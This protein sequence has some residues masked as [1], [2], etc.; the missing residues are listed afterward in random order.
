MFRRDFGYAHVR[1]ALKEVDVAVEAS[2]GFER[3][4]LIAK[5]KVAHACDDGDDAFSSITPEPLKL[6]PNTKLVRL[7]LSPDH[8]IDPEEVVAIAT[9]AD[10]ET[11]Y[12]YD[13]RAIPV[14][15][16]TVDV[17]L[18]RIDPDINET[19]TLARVDVVLFRVA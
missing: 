3:K 15:D 17:A 5:A 11:A 9:P 1:F 14:D 2:T 16:R 10:R 7:H 6:P 12:R 4:A 8:Q 18:R 19:L 13:V